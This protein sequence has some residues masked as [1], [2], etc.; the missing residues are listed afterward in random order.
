MTALTATAFLLQLREPYSW[1]LL[2]QVL[3]AGGLLIGSAIN[4]AFPDRAAWFAIPHLVVVAV[5]LVVN[6]RSIAGSANGATR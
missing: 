3:V 4:H 6:L 5:F 1:T 2:G